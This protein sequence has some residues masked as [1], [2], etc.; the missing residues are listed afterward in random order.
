MALSA[1]LPGV[2]LGCYR[3]RTAI[4]FWRYRLSETPSGHVRSAKPEGIGLQP[5]SARGFGVVAAATM[6]PAP[7]A[8]FYCIFTAT[9]AAVQQSR[10]ITAAAMSGVISKYIAWPVL[11]PCPA[12]QPADRRDHL[13]RKLPGKWG[14]TPSP[15][16]SSPT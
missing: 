9:V 6:R 15:G 13:A 2:S 11:V 8:L 5:I 14:T 3:S 16:R 7:P 12:S 4:G 10:H 1:F